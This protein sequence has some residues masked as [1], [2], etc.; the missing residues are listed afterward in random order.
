MSVQRLNPPTGMPIHGGMSREGMRFIEACVGMERWAR[1][2]RALRL[3]A[4]MGSGGSAV[5]FLGE[6]GH[7][8]KITSDSE[9]AY[10]AEVRRKLDGD[11]QI[12]SCLARVF[13]VEEIV[14]PLV[15]RRIFV[16]E[17]EALYPMRGW[18]DKRAA[19]AKYKC[20]E[21]V[22][23]RLNMDLL[24]DSSPHN[25]GL[26]VPGDESSAVLL[27]F[28]LS[29]ADPVPVRAHANPSPARDRYMRRLAEAQW[30]RIHDWLSKN[31][32]TASLAGNAYWK[33]IN[34]GGGDAQ[35]LGWRTSTIDPEGPDDLIV[36]FAS[37]LQRGSNVGGQ[38][39]YTTDKKFAVILLYGTFAKSIKVDKPTP[40]VLKAI[41]KFPKKF[42]ELKHIFVH[43]FTHFLD[44]RRSKAPRAAIESYSTDALLKRGG[45]KAYFL[46]PPEFNAYYQ[47]GFHAFEAAVRS[48]KA[49]AD[50][51]QLM[52]PTGAFLMPSPGLPARHARGLDAYWNT[53]FMT[54]IMSDPSMR[55]RFLKRLAMDVQAL[56][57]R[58]TTQPVTNPRGISP[59]LLNW[60]RT[61][62]VARIHERYKMWQDTRKHYIEAGARPPAEPS[63]T[64]GDLLDDALQHSAPSLKNS[65]DGMD[66]HHEWRWVAQK[67]NSAVRERLYASLK[68][69]LDTLVKNGKLGASTG[70]SPRTGKEARCYE[71]VERI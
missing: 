17:T 60:V 23:N 67:E 70:I 44:G 37:T 53:V 65:T 4:F 45:P 15:N 34:V 48:K 12:D 68:S 16:V 69:Y 41:M 40:A 5:A 28:G 10:A 36:A 11:P 56:N 71:P 22:G 64:V 31:T 50:M 47:E 18:R 35:A 58:R 8:F 24:L 30:E 51:E 43:E 62:A 54:A 14:E 20:L 55:K 26:R 63:I 52:R 13:S 21:A 57:E 38:M 1:I 27:D 59:E 46:S 66:I 29:G 6:N 49:S 2:R 19:E 7:V 9:D 39:S 32:K 61:W 42:R 25:F 3:K 33:A